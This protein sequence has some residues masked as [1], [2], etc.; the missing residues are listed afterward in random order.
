MCGFLLSDDEED[1]S[2]LCQDSGQGGGRFHHSGRGGMVLWLAADGGRVEKRYERPDPA[3]YRESESERG[4]RSDI[5]LSL[6]LPHVEGALQ[7]RHSD[8]SFYP[9]YQK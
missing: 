2:V 4:G 8:F 3:Q 9:I 5:C 1:S 6:L 7:E